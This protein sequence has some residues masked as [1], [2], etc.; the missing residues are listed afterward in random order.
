MVTVAEIYQT[1]ENTPKLGYVPIKGEGIDT[2][3]GKG[4][5]KFLFRIPD[6]GVSLGNLASC[7]EDGPQEETL[8]K[9]LLDTLLP[10]KLVYQIDDMVY[11]VTDAAK[12]ADYTFKPIKKKQISKEL[13]PDEPHYIPDE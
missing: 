11:A 2:K 1:L 10:A 3:I 13:E 6:K 5:A 12:N 4:V 7:Y 9:W 8:R